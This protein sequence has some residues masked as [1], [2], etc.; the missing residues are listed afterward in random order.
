MWRRIL[1][2]ADRHPDAGPVVAVVAAALGG[3]RARGVVGPIGALQQR[4]LLRLILEGDLTD[5]MP[6]GYMDTQSRRLCGAA[7]VHCMVMEATDE[8]LCAADSL[9]SDFERHYRR[10]RSGHRRR[11]ANGEPG[12]TMLT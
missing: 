2:L 8:F 12:Y 4:L 10:L 7:T 9:R 11:A 3:N 5:V 1:G 6:E